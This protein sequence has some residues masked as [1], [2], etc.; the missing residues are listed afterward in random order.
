MTKGA[1][2]HA[3]DAAGNREVD[4][5]CGDR[6][7][8]GATASSPDPQSRLIVAPGTVRAAPQAT[9]PC[10]RRCDCPR[11]LGSR[12]RRKTSSIAGGSSR[13]IRR[14][15]PRSEWARQIVGSHR[16]QSAAVAPDRRAH[17]IAKKGF[18]HFCGSAIAPGGPAVMNLLSGA[19]ADAFA[20]EPLFAWRPLFSSQKACPGRPRSGRRL[21][22]SPE[23]R[24]LTS[25]LG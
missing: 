20:S 13:G 4:V 18:G 9:P 25:F 17:P 12:I 24:S 8:R 7:R 19:L 2:D 6:A 21:R 22:R 10:A 5:A 3:F 14:A 23:G 15:P 1:R 11:P 16:R